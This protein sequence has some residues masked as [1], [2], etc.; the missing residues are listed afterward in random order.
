M[1]R[2]TAILILTASL[3]PAQQPEPAAPQGSRVSVTQQP[4]AE[5]APPPT[6]T[7]DKTIEL[8]PSIRN[9]TTLH[10]SMPQ[11]LVGIGLVVGLS[12]TG[13]TDRGSRLALLNYIQ[14][15]GLNFTIADVVGGSVALVTLSCDLPAFAKVGNRLDVKASV[16]GDATS[17]RGGQLIR[18][19]LRA[20]DGSTY[21]VAQGPVVVNGFTAQGNNAKVLQGITVSGWINNGGQVVKD[22]ESSF[23]SE[24][25]Y[26][27][28][29]LRN[30]SPYNAASVAAGVRGVAED[31]GFEVEAVDQALVRISV[32]RE[33]RTNQTALRILNAIADIRVPVENP[34]K[35]VI[36]PSSGTV[37]AG[38]GVLISPCVVGLSELTI[39]VMN[40]EDVVQPNPFAAGQTQRIGRSR[41]DV[42]NQSSE[43][44][45]LAGG[46]TVGDLLANLKTLGL[47][48]Q[49]LV[50]VFTALD[51][52]GFLQAKLE[53]R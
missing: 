36:D 21:V 51:G 52:G 7:F 6:V 46:A 41:I 42:Q 43:L 8:R 19:E 2:Q 17:L 3:L 11:A 39:A 28:L 50:A 20:V 15:E 24:S 37:L 48:P 27:E 53:V 34:A 33:Q 30:P 12:G 25:G 45:A 44:R 14:R 4:P 35:V 16:I 18:S 23:W 49:Q 32:P 1:S 40:D 29:R 31:M 47:T 9:I 38:E 5:P 13:S 26:L 22:L 10:N